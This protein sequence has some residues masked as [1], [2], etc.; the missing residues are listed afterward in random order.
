MTR[1]ASLITSAA[2][3]NLE[4]PVVRLQS[5]V[6]VSANEEYRTT[7]NLVAFA[8]KKRVKMRRC[9]RNLQ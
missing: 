8:T 7:D 2:T 3:S 1:P 6:V 9:L 4:A 5:N